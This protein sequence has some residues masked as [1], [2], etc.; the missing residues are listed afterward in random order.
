[1][2][3][4]V[5][6]ARAENNGCTVGELDPPA[7]TIQPQTWPTPTASDGPNMIGSKEAA[8][9]E[10][11]RTQGG[12]RLSGAV[13]LEQWPTPRVDEP[14]RTTKGYGRGLAE[15]VEGKEQ[16]WPTPTANSRDATPRWT[17]TRNGKQVVEPNLA[18]AVKMWLTP[19]VQDSKHSGTNSSE[20]GQRDLL[21][22]QVNWPTPRALEDKDCGPVGSKSQLHMEKRSYLCAKVKD[23]KRPAGQLNPNWVEQLMGVPP[24]WTALDGTS[25]EW[26]YGWH[27]GS[28]EAGI[29]RVTE[30][31]PDRVDRIRLLGNGVVPQ[32][33]AKAWRV[34][35]EQ[36]DRS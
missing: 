14:G 24:G 23:Q 1:M 17:K 32:T 36:L 10:N 2:V 12:V 25:N 28:W 22:N 16:M 27:D 5:N 35:E 6:E 11:D 19:Q 21:V 7:A 4:A 30:G 13:L 18:G 20:N 34:L 3:Q 29:P 33:A 26:H 31:C 9:K 15:L 8:A